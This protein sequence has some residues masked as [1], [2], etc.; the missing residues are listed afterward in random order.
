MYDIT[1]N[2]FFLISNKK[3]LDQ[4]V[5]LCMIRASA[6]QSLTKRKKE[7]SET[8]KKRVKQKRNK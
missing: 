7:K 5:N 1:L 2:T 3:T 6:R 4:K 8:K